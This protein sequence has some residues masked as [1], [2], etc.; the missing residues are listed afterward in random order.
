MLTEYLQQEMPSAIKKA[1]KPDLPKLILK[2]YYKNQCLSGGG[3]WAKNQ[4]IEE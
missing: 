2:L 3:G 4:D 1:K